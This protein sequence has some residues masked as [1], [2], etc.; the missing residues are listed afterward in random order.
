MLFL[1]WTA[2]SAPKSFY[3]N[4]LRRQAAFAPASPRCPDASWSLPSNTWQEA[5]GGRWIRD[6]G[7]PKKG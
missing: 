5:V 6:A 4:A 1:F 2:V 7:M 3:P